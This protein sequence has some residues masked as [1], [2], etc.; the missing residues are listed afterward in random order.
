MWYI[1]IIGCDIMCGLNGRN[2]VP[3]KREKSRVGGDWEGMG[4]KYGIKEGRR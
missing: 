1:Q 4:K 2:M 3:R